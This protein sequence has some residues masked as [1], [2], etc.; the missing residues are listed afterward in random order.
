MKRGASNDALHDAPTIAAVI[1]ETLRFAFIGS[2]GAAQE[3]V[4]ARIV[5]CISNVRH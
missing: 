5:E 2:S 1:V 4:F 3:S